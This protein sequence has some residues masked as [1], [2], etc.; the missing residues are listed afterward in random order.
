MKR[1]VFFGLVTLLTA[2]ALIGAE[3]RLVKLR[4][5]DGTKPQ[6]GVKVLVAYPDGVHTSGA[7][8]TLNSNSEGFVQFTFDQSVFWVTVPSLNA[9]V[10]GKRFDVADDA[11]RELR[12]DLRPREWRREAR[13]GEVKR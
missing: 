12:W 5:L 10:I 13:N 1:F 4:V 7:T 8:I 9:Q 6:S 3:S 11:P 2:S